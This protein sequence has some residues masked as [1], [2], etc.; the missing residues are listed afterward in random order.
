MLPAAGGWPSTT[1]GCAE[2]AKNEYGTNDVDLYE[3]A[4]DGGTDEFAQWTIVM[5]DDWDG[6]TVVGT[7]YWTAAAGSGTVIW[8]LQG[9]SF[10]NDDAIDQ[11]WGTEQIATDTIIATGDMHISPDTPAITLAGTPA[12]G[13]YV[14][15]RAYRD[16]DTDTSTND[17]SLLG[18]KVTYGTT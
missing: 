15:F 5:P 9:R 14:Q 12:A 13:E 10:G 4:F 17:A 6:S 16:A 11:S 8:Y 18:V 2:P 3:M 1:N 7:F